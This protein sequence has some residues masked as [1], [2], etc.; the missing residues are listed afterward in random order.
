MYI[1]A[2]RNAHIKRKGTQ[3]VVACLKLDLNSAKQVF[4]ILTS[5]PR[6]FL[7]HTAQRAV[8]DAPIVKTGSE[9]IMNKKLRY[10]QSV[11]SDKALIGRLSDANIFFMDK[12]PIILISKICSQDR[13]CSVFHIT[14]VQSISQNDMKQMIIVRI[15]YF[16]P[17][18]I[19]KMILIPLM[20][21]KM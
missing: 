19:Y 21:L 2:V 17:S 13:N 14:L 7:N 15:L 6:S 3:N 18:K 12:P 8:V 10:I 11:N 9:Q 5:S 16:C 4:A 1:S 20:N